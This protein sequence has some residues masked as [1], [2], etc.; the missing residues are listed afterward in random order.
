MAKRINWERVAI[1][2]GYSS[3]IQ[4]LTE[5]YVNCFLSSREI[6]KI[7][8]VSHQTVLNLLRKAEI[9]VNPRGGSCSYKKK[10]EREFK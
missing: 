10:I 3:L 7:F 2:K 6:G 1:H 4:M 5:M 8:E 9:P